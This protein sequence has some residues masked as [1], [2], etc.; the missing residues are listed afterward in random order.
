[1][2]SVYLLHIHLVQV[3]FVHLASSILSDALLLMTAAASMVYLFQEHALK[4]KKQIISLPSI[5][6]IDTIGLALLINAFAFMSIGI[7]AGSWMAFQEWGEKWYLDPRQIWSMANWTL[8]AFV[9]IARAW[10]GWRGRR[11]VLT[12]LSG[13]TLVLIGFFVIHYLSWSQHAQF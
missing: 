11:A 4:T 6:S 7:V 13:V 5:Q 8:F 10:V 2:T 12:T 9:L 3:L 1:M